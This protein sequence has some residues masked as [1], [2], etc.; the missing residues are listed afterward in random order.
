MNMNIRLLTLVVGA[1]FVSGAAA[2]QYARHM[3][4]RKA[5]AIVVAHS[6]PENDGA[7]VGGPAVDLDIDSDND[8]R[9][10]PPDRDATE[11]AHED[12]A[13]T[14]AHPG[15][16]L[17]VNSGDAD[18]DCIPDYADGYDLL[19][20]ET[21]DDTSAGSAFVPV[22]FELSEG[23]DPGH[24]SV[25][26]T[27]PASD[28]GAVTTN[29]TGGYTLPAGS[30]RLWR[31]NG[32]D[33]TRSTNTVVMG[34]DF[35]PSGMA[36]TA[37]QF[38]FGSG[39]RTVIYYVEAV[40]PSEQT[41]D[42]RILFVV[43]HDGGQ[44][45]RSASGFIAADAVRATAV[46]MEFVIPDKDGGKRP[47]SFVP[48][49][50][51]RPVV[52]LT[53]P[54]A[55]DVKIADG[56]ATFTLSGEVT[57]AI[58]DIIP[59]HLADIATVRVLVD[60]E[61][62]IAPTPLKAGDGGA[63]SFWRPHP[64]KGLFEDLPVEVVADG[65]HVVTV[66]TS[67]SAARRVGQDSVEL[68]FSSDEDDFFGGTNFVAGIYIATNFTKTVADLTFYDHGRGEYPEFVETA[69]DSLSFTGR[70]DEVGM[71]ISISGCSGLTTNVDELWAVMRYNI[72]TNY[73]PVYSNLFVETS[74]TPGLFQSISAMTLNR[75]D[76]TVK[77]RPLDGTSPGT[78]VPVIERVKGPADLLGSGDVTLRFMGDMFEIDEDDGWF[79][80]SDGAGVV[81]RKK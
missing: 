35:L 74:N 22:V 7:R 65:S 61:E 47:T 68:L 41:A 55:D 14:P 66:E 15:K 33:G 53:D 26:V 34:G 18:S 21:A 38:G 46:Q 44:I 73:Q 80:P 69:A 2:W 78:F 39:Q 70:M 23:I 51:P 54:A 9:F 24:A 56:R 32:G 4:V 45:N 29:G 30:L 8:N 43:A 67:A 63:A 20:S 72:S 36:C 28:P 76:L 77:V 49:S 25:R 79:Y 6:L 40:R 13:G 1:A 81:P 50:E 3:D 17:R 64:F 42:L 75:G 62:V 57:D 58:A 71:E 11:D 27:Y 60:G 5:R 52:T 19:S 31:R 16:I 37:M 10:S 12:I 59:R 48:V